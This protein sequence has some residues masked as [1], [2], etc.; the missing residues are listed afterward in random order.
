MR[1]PYY[2]VIYGLS[3]YQI[4]L[5]YLING[6]IFRVKERVIERKMNVLVFSVTFV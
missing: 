2:I 4:F 6:A 3:V 5:H 1:A